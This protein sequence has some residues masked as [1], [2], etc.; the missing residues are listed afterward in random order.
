[1]TYLGSRAAAS[2]RTASLARMALLAFLRLAFLVCVSLGRPQGLFQSLQGCLI[3][4]L[5]LFG[6]HFCLCL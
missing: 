5:P 4:H 2:L 1:V 3:H 6:S